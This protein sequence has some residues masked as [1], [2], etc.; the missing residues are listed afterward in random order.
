MPLKLTPKGTLPL[1]TFPLASHNFFMYFVC[2]FGG[3]AKSESA[4]WRDNEM[5]VSMSDLFA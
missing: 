2:L 3:N 1:G 4:V 5:Y